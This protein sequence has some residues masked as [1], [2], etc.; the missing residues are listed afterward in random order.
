MLMGPRKPLSPARDSEP[1]KSNGARSRSERGRPSAPLGPGD[2]FPGLEELDR[3]ELDE[4]DDG[5]ERDWENKSGVAY[6]PSQ[7]TPSAL[8]RTA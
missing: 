6:T 2:E 5:E 7:R 8:P 3:P 1:P 4:L